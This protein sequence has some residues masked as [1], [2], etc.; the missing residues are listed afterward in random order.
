MFCFWTC[1]LFIYYY[2]YFGVLHLKPVHIYYKFVRICISQRVLE[3]ISFSA[4]SGNKCCHGNTFFCF[5]DSF[6]WDLC[7]P[8]PYRDWILG[9]IF[10]GLFAVQTP[11]VM[12]SVSWRFNFVNALHSKPQ[13]VFDLFSFSAISG[14]YSCHGNTFSVVMLW[15]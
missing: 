2:Y 14:S 7:I 10:C 4:I 8:N 11:S 1:N 5:L 15:I 3:L 6:L 9:L 12:V 13:H